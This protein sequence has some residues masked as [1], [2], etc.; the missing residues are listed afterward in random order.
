MYLKKI[1]CIN[2]VTIP[3]QTALPIYISKYLPNPLPTHLPIYQPP[4]VCPPLLAL[5]LARP[6]ASV[7]TIA[8]HNQPKPFFLHSPRPKIFQ[9]QAA[10]FPFFSSFMLIRRDSN[11]SPLCLL[12]NY[13]FNVYANCAIQ[14][15]LEIQ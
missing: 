2:K 9:M 5:P 13:Q 3:C 11:P 15:R 14:A 10:L 8:S 1:P 7:P 12:I 6:R 4:T